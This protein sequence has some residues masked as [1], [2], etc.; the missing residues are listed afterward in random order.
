VHHVTGDITSLIA[1]LAK[2][3]LRAQAIRI[4]S[5]SVTQGLA[6]GL[7]VLILLALVQ[8]VWVKWRPGSAPRLA[9]LDRAWRVAF[10]YVAA[11]PVAT[12]IVNALPWDRTDSASRAASTVIIAS[13]VVG[14]VVSAVALLGPWRRWSF[15][16]VM[17]VALTTLTVLIADVTTGSHLQLDALFGLAPLVGGRFYGFGNVAF[18]LFGAAA[19]FTTIGMVQPYLAAGRRHAAAAI[20]LVTGLVCSLIDGWPRFGADFGGMIALVAAFATVATLLLGVRLT[21]RRILAIVA[22]AIAVPVVV[23]FLDWLRPAASRT[24]LGAFVQSVFDGTAGDTIVRKATAS[25]ASFGDFLLAPLVPVVLFA[26]A[27]VILVPLRVGAKR[28]PNAYREVLALRAGFIGCLV[29]AVVGWLVNDSGLI[30]T[31]VVMVLGIPLGVAA[32]VGVRPAAPPQP[33]APRPSEP[34]RLEPAP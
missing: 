20:A 5:Y 23:A 29:L 28:V 24:H 19:L 14:A 12:F 27:L 18:S 4:M 10:L 21:W 26:L 13:F 3:D 16:P 17:V 34:P 31:E 1:R 15:G 25:I 6:Y 32:V 9:K 2:Q 11:L 8:L 30:V 22:A 33:A 7:V